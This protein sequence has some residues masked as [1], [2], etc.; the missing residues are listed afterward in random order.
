MPN[1]WIDRQG[2][3]EFP[4]RSPNVTPM[5]FCVLGIIKDSAY[6]RKPKNV[7]DLR[8]FAIDAFANLDRDL[9]KHIYYSVVSRCQECTEAEE[10]SVT[11]IAN[12]IVSLD[13]YSLF[14]CN[15]CIF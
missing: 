4:L 2:R 11:V 10:T 14:G 15:T 9:C 7:E 1:N 6:S 5:D 8:Q 12:E 13:Y 3:I